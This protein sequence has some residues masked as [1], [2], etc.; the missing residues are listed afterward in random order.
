M[1]AVRAFDEQYPLLIRRPVSWGEMDAFGHVNNIVYFRYFEDARIAH[2]VRAGLEPVLKGVIGPILASTRARF[3]FPLTYPDDILI[4]SSAGDF[5]GSR[6]VMRYAVFSLRAAAVAC[7]GSADVVWF[8]YV[9]GEKRAVPPEV[10]TAL[11]S[12]IETRPP[13][14]P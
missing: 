12:R 9:A 4:G 11:E 2:F 7:E 5:D 14:E 6:F 1:S 13:L 8:D 10:R 3:R